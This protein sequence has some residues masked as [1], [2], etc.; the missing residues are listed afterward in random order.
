MRDNPRAS[1]QAVRCFANEYV[2]ENQ[3]I[4]FVSDG[5]EIDSQEVAR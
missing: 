1:A 3:T 4:S 5:E 2:A